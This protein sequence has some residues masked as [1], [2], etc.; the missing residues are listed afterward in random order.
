MPT[1]WPRCKA[2]ALVYSLGDR[3]A[4]KRSRHLVTQ[5]PRREA[6]VNT[7]ARAFYTPVNRPAVLKFKTLADK[8]DIVEALVHSALQ[9]G[10]N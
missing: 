9:T 3:L 4:Q 6:N 5:W 7:D 1:H 10:R 2:E 8:R